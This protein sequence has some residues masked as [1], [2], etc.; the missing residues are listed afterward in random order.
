V[1]WGGFSLLQA[2]LNLVEAALAT[3]ANYYLLLSGSDYPLCSRAKLEQVLETG[4]EFINTHPV[5]FPS[6]PLNRFDRY[7]FKDINRRKPSFKERSLINLEKILKRLPLKRQLPCRI[8]AGSTWFAL[9]HH[10]LSD[11]MERKE[12]HPDYL[13]FFKHSLCPDE[14]FFQTMISLGPYAEN[15][16]PNLSLV[17]WKEGDPSPARLKRADLEFFDSKTTYESRYG[18]HQ[19]CFGRKFGDEDK[20]LCQWIDQ[21]LL[22]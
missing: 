17:K 12:K 13:N 19:I 5:P 9:S 4:K 15:C 10:C 22:K 3:K 11:L 20:S 6:K 18:K 1:E 8:S 14:A 16:Q 7:H 21:V 2:S